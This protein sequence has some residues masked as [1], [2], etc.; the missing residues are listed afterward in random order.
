MIKKT[1]IVKL[2]KHQ[3]KIIGYIIKYDNEHYSFCTGKPSDV[4][5]FSWK[6]S[7][8]SDALKTGD[9]YFENYTSFK[10]VIIK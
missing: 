3:R 4:S 6:Y 2:Y 10:D 8:L 7:N 5:C 1:N 9:E